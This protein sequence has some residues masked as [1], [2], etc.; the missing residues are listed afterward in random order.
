MAP[1]LL[2][3]G[4]VN[5]LQKKLFANAISQGNFLS[6]TRNLG[7]LKMMMLKMMNPMGSMPVCNLSSLGTNSQEFGRNFLFFLSYQV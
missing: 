4:E 7:G 6:E 5:F 3:R 1:S 2:G